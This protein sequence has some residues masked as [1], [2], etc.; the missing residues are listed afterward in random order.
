[1]RARVVAGIIATMAAGLLAGCLVV[2][3]PSYD[4]AGSRGNIAKESADRFIPGVTT[5]EEVL[6]ELGEPD[7]AT[8]DNRRIGY[9]WTRV[10]GWW[11][12]GGGYSGAAGE[13]LRSYLLAIEF[14][15]DGR[16]VRSSLLKDWGG[17]VSASKVAHA[18]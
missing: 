9:E 11:F 13:V 4:A 1:M 15:A 2:P 5:R 16:F 8:R 18:L 7:H 12:V 17:E 3:V 10:K 6:L 14:D